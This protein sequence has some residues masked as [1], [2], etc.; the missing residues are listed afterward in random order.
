MDKVSTN[1]QN[2]REFGEASSEGVQGALKGEKR[3]SDTSVCKGTSLSKNP[4]HLCK[5]GLFSALRQNYGAL[6]SF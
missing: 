3:T 5:D 6:R 4:D 2:G 1:V